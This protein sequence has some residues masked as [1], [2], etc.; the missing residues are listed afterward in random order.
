MGKLRNLMFFTVI[1]FIFIGNGYFAFLVFATEDTRIDRIAIVLQSFGI[2][3]G[4]VFFI[5]AYFDSRISRAFSVR[6]KIAERFD[7][8]QNSFRDY[9]DQLAKNPE[10][11]LFNYLPEEKRHCA[12]EVA[13]ARAFIYGILF[14][15]QGLHKAKII[16]DVEI[17]DLESWVLF[18]SRLSEHEGFND[19][20]E[21]NSDRFGPLVATLFEKIHNKKYQKRPAADIEAL[22]AKSGMN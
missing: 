13:R 4:L 6:E 3:S 5:Y 19:F 1:A 9:I 16:H 20:F 11:G 21:Y 12:D 14:I 15:E 8:S 22:I 18:G 7:S 10:L 17:P 2:I